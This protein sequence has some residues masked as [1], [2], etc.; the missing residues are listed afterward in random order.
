VEV[1][2]AG[3]SPVILDFCYPGKINKPAFI[4][5]LLPGFSFIMSIII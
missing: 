1:F 2:F 5:I 4:K 3:K